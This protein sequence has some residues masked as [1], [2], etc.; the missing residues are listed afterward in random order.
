MAAGHRFIDSEGNV[1]AGPEC[2]EPLLAG[3][4]HWY[5]LVDRSSVVE[6]HVFD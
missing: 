4:A 6:W 1:V 5:V 2:F 3:P